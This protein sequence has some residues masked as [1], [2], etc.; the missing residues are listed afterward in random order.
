MGH[1]T[2][3]A[4]HLSTAV[5][6][7]CLFVL[8]VLGLVFFYLFVWFFGGGEVPVISTSMQW[9][10][11]SSLTGVRRAQIVTLHGGGY[12]ETDIALLLDSGAQ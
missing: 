1:A 12:T 10:K 11:K 5:G 3:F 7:F 4:T 2:E 9:A 8:C 6:R